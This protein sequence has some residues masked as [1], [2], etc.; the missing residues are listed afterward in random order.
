MECNYTT[1]GKMQNLENETSSP[2]GRATVYTPRDS[3]HVGEK[4]TQ[5][6]V[7]HSFVLQVILPD[8]AQCLIEI[9]RDMIWAKII[10]EFDRFNIKFPNEQ[11]RVNKR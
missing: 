5:C 3:R 2:S 7:D 1:N 9:N 10:S 4:D 6:Q 8:H 11:V